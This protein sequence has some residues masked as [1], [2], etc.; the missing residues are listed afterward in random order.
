M[1]DG[2]FKKIGTFEEIIADNIAI[3]GL[4]DDNTSTLNIG[5][6]MAVAVKNQNRLMKLSRKSKRKQMVI[7][8]RKKSRLVQVKY[9]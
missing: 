7:S 2:R 3:M 5:Q 4:T 1:I 8:W 9:P 6:P